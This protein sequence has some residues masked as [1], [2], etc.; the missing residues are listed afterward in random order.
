MKPGAII[1]EGH[2][3]GLSNTRSL[4]ELGIPVYVL[5]QTHCIARHS[6]YCTKFFLCPAFDSNEFIPFLIELAQKEGLRDWLIMP[7]NDQIVEQLSN[8]KEELQPFYCLVIPD[9]VALSQIVDKWALMQVAKE[10]G[11]NAPKSWDISDVTRMESSQFPVLKH[12]FFKK[13]L[14]KRRNK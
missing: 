4:G 6:K 13:P 8:Y 2:V 7:S 10:A 1:I 3:Q 12:N 5:D 9:P 11:T 14:V